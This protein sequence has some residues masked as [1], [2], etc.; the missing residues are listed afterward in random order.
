VSGN[1]N[2]AGSRAERRALARQLRAE[3]ADH[4][5]IASELGVSTQSVSRYLNPARAARERARNRGERVGARDVREQVEREVRQQLTYD[6]PRGGG[7]GML[8]A[9]TKAF[10]EAMEAVLCDELGAREAMRGAAIDIASAGIC[11]AEALLEPEAVDVE[12]ER[13]AA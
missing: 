13:V 1:A 9:R 5:T 11:V 2:D 3:G 12:S 7:Q 10:G 6:R 4:M 8:L